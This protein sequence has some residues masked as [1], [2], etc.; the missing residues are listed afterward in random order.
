MPLPAFSAQY[1]PIHLCFFDLFKVTL[2]NCIV[3]AST[4]LAQNRRKI[5]EFE[6]FLSK[7]Q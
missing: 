7:G 2:N 5:P 1:F 6:M 4:F 3:P